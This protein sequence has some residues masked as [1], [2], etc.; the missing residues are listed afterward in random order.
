MSLERSQQMKKQS[1]IKLTSRPLSSQLAR[2]TR[3]RNTM[4]IKS[5]NLHN[6]K[7]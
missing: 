5:I 6:T 7:I 4:N 2:E 3:Q 1:P